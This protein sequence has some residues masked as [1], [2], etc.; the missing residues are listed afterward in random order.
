MPHLRADKPYLKTI[1]SVLDACAD[2]DTCRF[3]MDES[4]SMFPELFRLWDRE[5]WEHKPVT[6]EELPHLADLCTLCGLCPCPDIRAGLI[7]G[8]TERVQTEG[9]PLAIRLLADVQTFGRLGGLAPGMAN[10]LLPLAPVDRLAKKFGRVHRQRRLPRLPA[11]SFFAW[12]RRRGLARMPEIGPK[13]AYFAG[14]SAGYLFP[15]VARAAVDVLQGQGIAVHVPPQQC[16]G[17]PTLLEGDAETTLERVR[18]NLESLLEAA[19]HGL[20]IVCSC[21]TCGYLM[22]VLLA[23]DAYYAEAYQRSVGAGADEI[24]LPDLKAGG[25]GFTH[26]K[27]SMYHKVLKDDGYFSAIDPLARIALSERVMDLGEFLARLKDKGRQERGLSPWKARVAYFAPCHQR[28]QGIGS[29]YPDLLARIPDLEVQA[30][31]GPLD[32]CGMGGSL[33]FKAD[34][35][36]SAVAL[37]KP[38]MRKIEA[39]SPDAIVTDCLSCRLQFEHLLPYPVLHPLEVL[40]KACMGD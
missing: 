33:G 25:N 34:F 13:V 12:A 1:R 7:R 37:A 9:M 22:K 16:C 21:P 27:K 6:E 26:L 18:S 29:P 8:K 10:R 5:R 35:H 4:C 31:G 20:Y 11:E 36:D 39:A 40:A 17:M 23:R 3:L 24:R 14:C 19:G 30:V 15:Q 32:C 2:C 28:E 38:L